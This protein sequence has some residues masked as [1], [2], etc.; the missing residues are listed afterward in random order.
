MSGSSINRRNS[1]KASSDQSL[2]NQDDEMVSYKFSEFEQ[3]DIGENL[4]K[5]LDR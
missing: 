1:A 4:D 3:S 2:G 5:G